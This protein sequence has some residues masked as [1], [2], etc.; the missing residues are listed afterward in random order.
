VGIFKD[1][2]DTNS[3]SADQL[4]TLTTGFFKKDNPEDRTKLHKIIHYIQSRKL[5]SPFPLHYSEEHIPQKLHWPVRYFA[6]HYM[7]HSIWSHWGMEYIKLLLLLSEDHPE[8][9]TRAKQ[10]MEYYK[11]RIEKYGGYPECYDLKGNPLRERLYRTVLHT[12]WVIN[13]EQAK[14]LYNNLV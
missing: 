9:L 11:K 12:S 4:I 14:V 2:L 3:F 5:D 13:Y 6:P 10:H 7:S 1:D 8:Y